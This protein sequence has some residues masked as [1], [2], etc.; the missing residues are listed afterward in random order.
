MR[1][2]KRLPLPVLRYKLTTFGEVGGVHFRQSD[3][4]A[5]VTEIVF[6]DEQGHEI[7]SNSAKA[8]ERIFF[9]ENFRRVHFAEPGAIFELPNIAD[10]Y[11]EGFLRALDKKQISASRPRIVIDL[12]HAPAADILQIGRAHV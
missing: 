2:V 1:D 12:N 8:I 6:F 10:Y 3:R 11:C 7:S 9:K 4:D 5:S